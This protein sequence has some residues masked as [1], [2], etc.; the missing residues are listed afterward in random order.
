MKRNFFLI[1]LLI[2]IITNTIQPIMAKT[3]NPE[4]SANAAL[5][6]D[7]STGRALYKK[8]TTEKIQPGGFTK[9][10]TA[11]VAM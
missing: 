10:M 1:L 11:I 2:Y 3:N 6:V 7:V 4:L 8:N 9:I 5:L